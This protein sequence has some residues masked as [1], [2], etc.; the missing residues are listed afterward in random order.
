MWIEGLIDMAEEGAAYE[1]FAILKRPD[2]RYVTE[3]A[4]D[5]PKFVEN[6]AAQ[7]DDDCRWR[8]TVFRCS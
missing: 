5:D 2:E 8:P 3:R 6:S 7:P 4:Y 1:L